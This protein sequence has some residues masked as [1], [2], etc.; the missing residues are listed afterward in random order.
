MTKFSTLVFKTEQTG[1]PEYCSIDTWCRFL[2]TAHDLGEDAER[3]RLSLSNSSTDHGGGKRPLR[4]A[5]EK[6]PFGVAK[7]EEAAL[8][9][10]PPG[11]QIPHSP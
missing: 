9:G 6:G 10:R 2:E 11:L 7:S 5:N 3:P 8:A 4:T 1:L